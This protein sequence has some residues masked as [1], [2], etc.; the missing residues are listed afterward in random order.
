MIGKDRAALAAGAQLSAADLFWL[1]VGDLAGCGLPPLV[2]GALHLG[3]GRWQA[4]GVWVTYEERRLR[5]RRRV[6]VRRVDRARV[7][8]GAV[9]AT[10]RLALAEALAFIERERARIVGGALSPAEV[11]PHAE[12][13]LALRQGEW[14]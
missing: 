9:L 11:A 8:G 14:P 5:S 6:H 4:V 2:P 7:L 12:E 1:A 3:A 10:E 13:A